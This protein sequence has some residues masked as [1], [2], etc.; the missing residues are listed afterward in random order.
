LIEE[1]KSAFFE[2]LLA[3]NEKPEMQEGDF[4]TRSRRCIATYI[5]IALNKPHH[6]AAAFSGVS[7][8]A[9]DTFDSFISGTK[10]QAFS[11]LINIVR[12]GIQEGVLRP[13]LDIILASKSIWASS[14][15]LVALMTHLPHFAE[16]VPDEDAIETD[17]FIAAHVD[18]IMRGLELPAAEQTAA[19]YRTPGRTGP[20][21]RTV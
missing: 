6:Y 7:E 5:K 17:D 3:E 16:F 11:I 10:G 2:L 9:H 12:E 21:I 14:H 19:S 18:Q 4:H 20:V 1:L 8:N 15:G 13:D